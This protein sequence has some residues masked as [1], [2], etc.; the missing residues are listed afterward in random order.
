MKVIHSLLLLFALAGI[1][2][3]FAFA[4]QPVA[5]LGGACCKTADCCAADCCDA[6]SCC[7]SAAGCQS[8]DCKTCGKKKSS[9]P[10]PVTGAVKSCCVK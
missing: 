5:S 9:S 8:A 10:A 7:D 3:T 4:G 1:A 2:V 6:K